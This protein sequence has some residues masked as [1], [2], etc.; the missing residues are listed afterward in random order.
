MEKAAA[1]TNKSKSESLSI[2]TKEAPQPASPNILHPLSSASS[3]KVPSP[4]FIIRIL[5]VAEAV[6]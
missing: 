4:L 5:P 2:S 3:V 1:L 6:T